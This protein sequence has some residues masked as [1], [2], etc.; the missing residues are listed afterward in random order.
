MSDLV[1]LSGG[2]VPLPITDQAGLRRALDEANLPTLVAVH[3]TLTQDMEFLEQF[4]PH[5]HSL[6]SGRQTNIPADLAERLKADLFTLLTSASPPKAS[7]MTIEKVRRI[8][9][10]CVGEEVQAEFVPVLFEQMGFE[11]QKPRKERPG[12]PMPAP[13]FKVLMIGGGMTGIA[14]GIKLGEAGYNYTIVEKNSELGGTWWENRYPGV[15][16]DTPSHFYSYSFELNPDWSHYHPKG[17]E[18]QAYLLRAAEKHDVRKNVLFNTKVVA[19]KWDDAAALWHVTVEDSNGNRRNIDANAVINGH[20]VLNRWSMPNIP[21][22]DE[23]KGPKMHTAGWD[24]SVDL[25]G[26]R[27]ALIGTGASGVQV[28]VDLA[29]RLKHLTVFQ[30]SRH[31][32]MCNDEIDNEVTDGVKFALRHIPHYQQWFRFR[33][34]WFT[35]D[36]LYGNVVRDPNWTNLDYS[37]SPQNDGARRFA[38]SYIDRKLADRPDLLEKIKPDYP[39]FCKRIV[40]DRGGQWLDTLKRNNVTLDT[41]SID[42]I[43]SDAIVMKDG[44]RI[45]VDAIAL[46]TGFEVANALGPLQIYGRNGVHLN[47][48]WGEDDPRAYLGLMAPGYPNLFLTLGPNSAPN[49]AAGVNMVLEAQLN[50]VIEALDMIVAH[51]A[52]IIEPT[53]EAYLAWNDKV[54]T[55]MKDMIWTHPK[56]KSYY[57]NSKG[58]N[59]ISC[60][61]RLADYWSWTR[62]PEEKDMKIA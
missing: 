11:A 1:T 7:P 2:S 14:A 61:F 8:M 38:E 54:D 25:T 23:F 28:A 4:A 60:P 56:A 18:V 37:I 20:G 21:G 48:I 52:R 43:E 39:I 58:R 50:Y 47:P 16:V 10:I 19:L 24:P 3:A 9:E 55:Q 62:K 22:L 41:G 6:F 35:G 12:R 33:V 59:I 32:V 17:H 27:V 31:W 46:A 57:L 15:G 29:P 40:L 42:H 26:K 13:D 5:I 44:R 36:G 49:H 45:E 51:G 34:Y 30:R 53:E